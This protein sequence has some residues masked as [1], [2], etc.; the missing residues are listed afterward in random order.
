MNNKIPILLVIIWDKYFL[1]LFE[2]EDYYV[3]Q[4]C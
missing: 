4:S 1:T 3:K 2:R